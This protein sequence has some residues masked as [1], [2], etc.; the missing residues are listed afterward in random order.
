MNLDGYGFTKTKKDV[1]AEIAHIVSDFEEVVQKEN[2]RIDA[3]KIDE[4]NRLYSQLPFDLY[5]YENDKLIFW[6]NNEIPELNANLISKK[7]SLV[8]LR[9]R[10]YFAI[11]EVKNDKTFL[12]LSLI[13]N[14]YSIVNK[15]LSNSYSEQFKFQD[16]DVILPALHSSGEPIYAPNNEVVFKVHR[17]EKDASIVDPLKLII[18]V[19]IFSFLYLFLYN[20]VSYINVSNS[21]LGLGVSLVFST[22]YFFTLY[23]IPFEFLKTLIFKPELY[24]ITLF[25]SL[26]HLFIF[27]LLIISNS[28]LILL[29][30][31]KKK[32]FKTSVWKIVFLILSSLVFVFSTILIKSLVLDSIIN[33]RAENFAM[34]DAYSIFGLFIAFFLSMFYVFFARLATQN[35]SRNKFTFLV[36]ALASL[37]VFILLYF[38]FENNTIVFGLSFLFLLYNGVLLM[39]KNRGNIYIY[40]LYSIVFT[41][42]HVSL[43]FAVYSEVK[44]ENSKKTFAS[45][46]AR[47]R[48]LTAENLYIRVSEKIHSDG[49]VKNYYND[50][51]SSY[52]DLYK[53]LSYKYFNGYYSKFDI[54][55]IPFN[56]EGKPI[57]NLSELSLEF[58]YDLINKYGEETLSK[59][60]YYVQDEHENYSYVSLIQIEEGKKSVGTLLIKI[61]PKSY[62]IGNVYPELLL[63]G[64]KKLINQ[65]EN[66]FDY[67]IYVND[68]LNAKSGDFV[69]PKFIN[70][71]D[72]SN[73]NHYYLIDSTLNKK[74]ILSNKKNTILDKISLF[75]FVLSFYLILGFFTI[76]SYYIISDKKFIDVFYFT[77]RKKITA[78][79]LLL[80]IASFF[81]FGITTISYFS[82]QYNSYHNERLIRKESAIL[83]SIDYLIENGNISSESE[84]RRYFVVSMNKDLVE[85]SDIHKMDVNIFDKKGVLLTS[86][87]DGIFTS[88]LISSKIN[89][90]AFISLKNNESPQVIQDERIGNLNYLAAY[91]PI[92][93]IDGDVISYLNIPYFSKEKK[94]N[95]DISNFMISLVNVYVI[96]FIIGT[97]IAFF[98]SNSLTNPLKKISEKISNISLSKQNSPIKWEG[99]DEI[100]ALVN[101]YNK[102]IVELAHSANLLAKN[103]RDEAWREMAKQI[104][105]EIKNP[106]TPMKLSIQYLQKTL[107]EDPERALELAGR[108]SKTLVEQID[109]LTDIATAFSSFAKM[110]VANKEVVSLEEVMDA[111][112][113]LFSRDDKVIHKDYHI[114]DAKIF[115]D[116]NQ[117]ISV[118]NNL[119]KNALQAT[120][121]VEDA[122]IVVSLNDLNHYFEI[123]V[124]DNGLGIPDD[125]K[126]KVFVPNFTTKSSGTGLGLA[127]SKQIIENL[128]GNIRFESEEYVYTKFYVQIPKFIE[129]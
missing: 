95:Q 20:I 118:F 46:K 94:L 49:F 90:R 110:P 105:H 17:Q 125:K 43:I 101:E 38:F 120:E 122:K 6:N 124:E 107:K 102:M 16:N 126:H 119:V 53:R 114:G 51:L 115:A 116:K 70:E 21:F 97:I 29:L 87:Q 121:E 61:V 10:Y 74:V 83:R 62:D 14:S 5:V 96:L 92:Y 15:Y 109:N 112:I 12:G 44:I 72:D 80:V 2:P 45:Q 41:V 75:S 73:Y 32:V 67:A 93:G 11:K 85:L 48:D 8:S 18:S 35:C 65:Y 40:I 64:K 50:P 76:F 22:F 56:N 77:F 26:G 100:G 89:P 47:Q 27:T 103:E 88:G 59:E 81:V 108:V 128:K 42:M 33:F 25:K 19:L 66:E 106:L 57:K 117:M 58:F 7:I 104:A 84:L 68:R 79:M 71:I 98:V 24:S 69:Y 9:N 37:F 129:S 60:L 111:A 1:E 55:I 28:Y 82:K 91:V 52:K 3:I 86:S 4:Y 30:T 23:F 99:N 127:I 54:T 36:F 31:F 63:E 123:T 78:S 113:D 39:F 13:R 34:I